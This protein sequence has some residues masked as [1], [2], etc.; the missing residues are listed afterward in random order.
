MEGKRLATVKIIKWLASKLDPSTYG[1]HSTDKP[2]TD[3]NAMHLE[4]IRSLVKD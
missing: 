1:N 4:A 3:L 2:Q